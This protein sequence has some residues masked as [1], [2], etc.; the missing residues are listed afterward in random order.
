VPTERNSLSDWIESNNGSASLLIPDEWWNLAIGERTNYKQYRCWKRRWYGYT[1][2]KPW[3]TMNYN[4]GWSP[5]DLDYSKN[6]R[7][8]VIEYDW[9]GY[10]RGVDFWCLMAG[11]DV[12][13]DVTTAT[14]G[15]VLLGI[16]AGI[17][18]ALVCDLF[19]INDDQVGGKTGFQNKVNEANNAQGTIIQWNDS[20]WEIKLKVE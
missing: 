2:N 9:P 14:G 1:Q 18:T 12:G 8:K 15:N 17:G 11:V 19:I 6:Y 10:D 13:T 16:A 20:D 4:T 5:N 7:L 3:R